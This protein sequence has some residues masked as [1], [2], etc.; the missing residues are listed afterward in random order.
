ML[1]ENTYYKNVHD[2][3]EYQ[4]KEDRA[5][6]CNKKWNQFANEATVKIK[7]TLKKS[8]TTAISRVQY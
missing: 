5:Q 2:N 4:Y 8:R 6:E 3:I 7:L 1:N